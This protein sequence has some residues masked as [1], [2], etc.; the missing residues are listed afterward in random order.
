MIK[1]AVYKISEVVTVAER[2]MGVQRSSWTR[3]GKKGWHAG[4]KF[5]DEC[6]PQGRKVNGEKEWKFKAARNAHVY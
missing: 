1:S 3:G 4:V 6:S 5:N 2:H